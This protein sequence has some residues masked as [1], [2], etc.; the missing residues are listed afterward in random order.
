MK[1]VIIS[2]DNSCGKVKISF[3]IKKKN[4]IFYSMVGKHKEQ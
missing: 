2:N 4:I 3:N 1:R